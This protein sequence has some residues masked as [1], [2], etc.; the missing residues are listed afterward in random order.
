MAANHTFEKPI[1]LE[2]S[3]I[4]LNEIVV[5]A[6]KQAITLADGKIGIDTEKL[7][8]GNN[9]NVLDVLKRAPGV[10]VS[11]DAITVQGND[12]LVVIDGVKQRM[13]MGILLTYLKSMPAANLKRLFI[14]SMATAENRL[15]GEDAT[16]E[17]QTKKLQIRGY[18]DGVCTL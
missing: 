5:S 2:E 7:R 15:S 11:H 14:K 12:P 9:D 6:Y 18:N 13:P 16:I 4:G 8:L 10:V 1:A 17:L 3:V